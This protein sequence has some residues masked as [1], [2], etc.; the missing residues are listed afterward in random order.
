MA[1]TEV[2]EKERFG[3][4]SYSRAWMIGAVMAL[5]PSS[6]FAQNAPVPQAPA[7][8][9]NLTPKRITFDR[10]GK[11]AT[12]SVSTGS[13]S[14]A[15]DV[16]MIDRVMLPDGQIIPLA[17]AA[18]KPEAERL[19]SAKSL[20]VVRPAASASPPARDRRSGCAPRLRLIWRRANID[21]T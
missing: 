4:R 18:G 19:K 15:F 7:A 20:L 6:G 21:P 10:P 2:E 14:G 3:R 11:S 1:L 17:D 8:S 16:E 13:G 9:V 5:L 12:V